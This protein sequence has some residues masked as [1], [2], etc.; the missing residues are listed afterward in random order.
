MMAAR[1]AAES[2]S[3]SRASNVALMMA[4]PPS[5]PKGQS[6]A[7]STWFAPKNERAQETASAEPNV[8][9]SA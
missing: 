4:R 8:A 1:S 5:G 3:W 7:K 9:V 6:V 2:P